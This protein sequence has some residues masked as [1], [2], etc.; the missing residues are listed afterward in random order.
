VV[1]NPPLLIINSGP[2]IKPNR[3]STINI[4]LNDGSQYIFQSGTVR[5]NENREEEY[6]GLDAANNSISIFNL[7]AKILTKKIEIYQ[8]GPK[9]IK[10]ILNFHVHTADSIFIFPANTG[11]IYL[12]D[13]NAEIID[14]WNYGSLSLPNGED[15][16]V[17]FPFPMAELGTHF[18]YRKDKD[19][20]TLPLWLSGSGDFYKVPP[21]IH[22][23]LK[24]NSVVNNFGEYPDN[25][26]GKEVLIRDHFNLVHLENG[27]VLISFEE[28]HFIQ[29]YSPKGEYIEQFFSEK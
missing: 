5:I 29:K 23:D 3:I 17:N 24:N 6:W 14:K 28:S 19:Y 18:Y 2:L 7:S 9:A 20:V 21:L 12:I 4:P 22:Y 25:Y 27:E 26:N 15:L 8:S 13:S 16:S 10:N 1:H 11:R